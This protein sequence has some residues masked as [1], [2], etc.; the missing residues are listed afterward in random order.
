MTTHPD[1]STGDRFRAVYSEPGLYDQVLLPHYFEGVTDDELVRHLL[2]DH[3]G[4]PPAEPRLM[5][6]EFG[7]GTGRITRHLAP[8]ARR[9]LAVDNSP[10]M[11]AA[12]AATS[13][14]A[15]TRCADTTEAVKALHREGA[16]GRFDVL[17]AFWSL[18]YP[19][20]AYVET[21]TSDGIR[22]GPDPASGLRH[23]SAFVDALVELLAPGG[24][25]F[26]LLFDADSPEQ[27][28]VTR[29]WE[30]VAPT[31]FGDRGYTRKILTDALT[32]AEHRG[33]GKLRHS[34]LHGFAVAPDAAA[35]RRWFTAAHFKDLPA[36]TGNQ[37]LMDDV[38]E[39]IAGCAQPDGTVHLPAGVH[40]I[41]FHRTNACQTDHTDAAERD[42]R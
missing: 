31:P 26:A 16:A 17:G 1:D 2:S 29:A 14:A 13:P 9:L 41:D 24:H 15:E 5:V 30:T 40:V 38:E 35:A 33:Q 25:L 11:T 42:D 36:L 19:L 34:H 4:P 37:E 7:C 21:L 3:Y 18:S 32:G 28:L 6:A 23:A 10:A 12:F 22:T 8:Y 39:F 27:R 20:G